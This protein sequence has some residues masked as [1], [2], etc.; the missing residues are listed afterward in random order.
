[1]RG[2]NLKVSV[3]S[4]TFKY[5]CK[6][7]IPAN[8]DGY[9]YLAHILQKY[10]EMVPEYNITY[11]LDVVGKELGSSRSRAERAIRHMIEVSWTNIT[12]DILLKQ[13]ENSTPKLGKPT[14]ASYL[15]AVAYDF[16]N[17]KEK[18]FYK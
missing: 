11:V 14:V 10:V 15:T 2:K 9:K 5:L 18:E 17:Y 8:L 4:E 13:I 1:M 12:D 3:N 6:L 7:G 16:I